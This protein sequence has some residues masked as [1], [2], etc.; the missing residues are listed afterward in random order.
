DPALRNQRIIKEADDAA[1]AVILVDVV[2]GFGSH[3]NPAAV[4]LEG[5]HEAQKRLKAQGREVIFVAYVLGTD[6]DPQYKQAQ[7]QQ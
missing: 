4:T 7:V 5:I 6:N 2:L 3:E 1:A